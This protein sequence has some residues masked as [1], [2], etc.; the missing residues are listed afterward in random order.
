MSSHIAIAIDGPAASGKSTLGRHLAERLG[1]IMVNSGAMYRAITWKAL[2][3]EIDTDD[4][5]AVEAM[6]GRIEIQCSSKG[7]LSTIAVDGVDPGEQL[8][9]E[10]VNTKVSAISAIPAVFEKVGAIDLGRK[11]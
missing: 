8:R 9:S 1:L 2:Q 7:I 10:S 4:E 5:E 3:E 11:R 6:L